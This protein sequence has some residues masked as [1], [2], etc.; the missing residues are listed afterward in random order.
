MREG[1]LLAEG[2]EL[3]AVPERGRGGLVEGGTA[4]G[5]GRGKAAEAHV[6]PAPKSLAA[7]EAVGI[8]LR[9]LETDEGR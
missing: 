3:A 2:V 5:A 7:A 1:A 6:T 8:H 4:G 9:P